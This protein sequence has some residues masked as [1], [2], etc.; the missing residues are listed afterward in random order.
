MRYKNT[1]RAWRFV[2]DID[3]S[4]K[5][6]QSEFFSAARE[7]VNYR[8][9]IVKLWR[10]L[11]DDSS[12][13][14]GLN[15][16]DLEAFENIERF[17]TRCEEVYVRDFENFVEGGK[18]SM[19]TEMVGAKDEVRG[20]MRILYLPCCIL[21]KLVSMLCP[22]EKTRYLSFLYHVIVYDKNLWVV[23]EDKI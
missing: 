9:N 14:I 6:S 4:G 7:K 21:Y 23:W 17:Q 13:L 15:E 20:R 10:K 2:F 3:G 1:P 12:G 8:G 11:D 22:Q 18:I 5:V 16:M 19:W